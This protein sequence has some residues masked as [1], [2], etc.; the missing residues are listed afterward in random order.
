MNS[1]SSNSSTSA[2]K[3]HIMVVMYP[4]WSSFNASFMLARQLMNRGCR[5]VYYVV[6]APGFKEYIIDSGF[7]Y[8]ELSQEFEKERIKYYTRQLK[9]KYKYKKMPGSFRMYLWKRHMMRRVRRDILA[10]MEEVL[11]EQLPDL[12]LLGPLIPDSSIP[13]LKLKIPIIH[14]N[15]TLISYP[16]SRV[17]PVFSRIIPGKKEGRLSRVRNTAA[18][19]RV[20]MAQWLS[21]FLGFLV[22][23]LTGGFTS[24]TTKSLRKEIETYGGRLRRT[25]YFHMLDVPMLVTSPREFDFPRAARRN[26][27][28]Y[29]GAGIYPFRKEEPFYWGGIDKQKPI[30][31]C[32]LGSYSKNWKYRRK[33]YHAVIKAV[34]QRPGWQLI[35]QMPDDEDIDEFRPFPANV[36][37]EKWVPHLEVLPHTT[38]VICHAGFGTVREAVY[39]GVPLIVF[40]IERDQPAYA[41]RVVYHGLG[42]MGNIK[43][44][45]PRIMNKLLERVSTDDHIRRS[46]RRMQQVFRDQ[47]KCLKG[48]EFIE[49][50]LTNKPGG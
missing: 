19:V 15:Y 49:N 36:F 44:I 45:T 39:F 37:V 22:S 6:C 1:E 30:V 40:P 41:A 28:C 21:E 34:E 14:L 27:T 26:S 29:I 2:R 13:F 16:T 48:V 32:T 7:E 47:E 38:V 42:L 43:K 17:P 3:K 23:R 18:W 10:K 31:Y 24:G 33:L 50:F 5:V 4:E 46:S 8:Q 9:E 12:V 35:L 20:L 25:D 11:R